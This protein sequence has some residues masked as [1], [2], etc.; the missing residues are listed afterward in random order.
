MM[1]EPVKAINADLSCDINDPRNAQYLR[2]LSIAVDET[3]AHTMADMAFCWVAE[4]CAEASMPM[5]CMS[6]ASLMR[7]AC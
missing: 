1:K 2:P 3:A 7:G 5:R 4:E 6:N